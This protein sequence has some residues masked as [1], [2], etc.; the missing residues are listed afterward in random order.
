MEVEKKARA[1][2]LRE[3]V[4]AL[5][6]DESKA[7]GE[8]SPKHGIE[9]AKQNA[10]EKQAPK[11][12]KMLHFE[13]RKEPCNRARSK[14][15]LDSHPRAPVEHEVFYGTITTAAFPKW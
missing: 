3:L 8:G 14:S 10:E 2:E 12:T 7:G 1:Q 9:K 6:E 13:L 15:F 5:Q 4:I 11:E